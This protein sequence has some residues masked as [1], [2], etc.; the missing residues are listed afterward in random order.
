MELK[1][2]EVDDRYLDYDNLF[3]SFYTKENKDDVKNLKIKPYLEVKEIN[4]IL[5]QCLKTNNQLEREI[6]K[7]CKL[8]EYCTN[9]D[10]GKN[11]EINGEEI[12]N[13]IYSNRLYEII[14]G[15]VDNFYIIDDLLKKQESLY[16]IFNELS[17]IVN[18]KLDDLL[19]QYNPSNTK[20]IIEEL[21][22][23]IDKKEEK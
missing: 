19:K 2:K 17:N 7:I 9:I 23:I 5:N 12:Y 22:K 14:E 3:K 20:E 11:K 18:N 4:D 21:K 10:L 1:F 15:N 6:I 16:E 8:V 13:F